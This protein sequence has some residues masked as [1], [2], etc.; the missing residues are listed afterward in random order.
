MS[1][2]AIGFQRIVVA[3]DTA[4]EGLY[5]LEA[6]AMLA[7]GLDRPVEAVFIEDTDLLSLAALPFTWETS[8][9]GRRNPGFE[10]RRVELELRSRARRLRQQIERMALSRRLSVSF[11]VV[12]G[13]RTEELR[14][15]RQSGNLLALGLADMI[16]IDSPALLAGPGSRLRPG[17]VVLLAGQAADA[18][19]RAL[20]EAL[21]R[22]TEQPLQI[23]STSMAVAADTQEVERVPIVDLPGRL[24]LLHR[25]LLVARAADL[26][27]PPSRL[28]RR[29]SVP[30][31]LV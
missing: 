13:R 9:S 2:T 26:P 10:P 7:S 18:E 29:L 27:M 20:A 11:R 8:M 12:R 14:R 6:A 31:V 22:A 3:L 30:L 4:P 15:L 16:E 24:Q 17:P 23:L 28:I 1:V 5:A 21:A 19:T 25:G